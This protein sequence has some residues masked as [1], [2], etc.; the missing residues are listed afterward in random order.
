MLIQPIDYFLLV[1]FVLSAASTLCM[2]VDQYRNNPQPVVM[3]WGFILAS[4]V[5]EFIRMNFMMAA[6]APV[7]RCPGRRANR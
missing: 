7:A 1:W 3:K 2:A 6:M 5:P 4:F